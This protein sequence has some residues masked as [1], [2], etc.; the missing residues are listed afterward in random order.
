MKKFKP[1][2][3]NIILV[4]TYVLIIVTGIMY[5]QPF[6]RMLPLLVSGI[7][8]F[9]QSYANRYGYLLGGVNCLLYTIV[10][11]HIGTYGTA[12]HDI[13][14]SLPI[15]LLT[16]LYWKKHAYKK[17]VVFRKLSGK[18]RVILTI[19]FVVAFAAMYLW[20]M[21]LGSEYA[22]LDSFTTILGTYVVI[23]TMLAYIEYAY[24]WPV[25]TFLSIILCVQVFLNEPSQIT[26]LIS[27]LYGFYCVIR[28]LVNVMKLYNEQKSEVLES[29]N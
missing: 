2:A 7:V 28:A 29:E 26:Y 27:S 16:F 9:L 13:A 22:L 23:L 25:N 15:Q 11:I 21:K 3:D 14:I 19:L 20:L 24:L 10:H 6:Y 5:K 18:M 8:M 1:T 12:L 4:I 17:C